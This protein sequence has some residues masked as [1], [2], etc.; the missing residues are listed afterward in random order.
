M[1]K[2]FI[3]DDDDDIL[4]VMTLLFDD[5]PEVKTSLN[6]QILNDLGPT[7]PDLVILD[8]WLRNERGSDLCKQLKGDPITAGI[9]VLLFTASNNGQCTADLAGADGF[10]SKPFDINELQAV[11]EKL[12]KQKV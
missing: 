12:I 8:D 6:G 4:N 2:I 7:H 11:V 1:S 5:E 3:I 10:I 9:P